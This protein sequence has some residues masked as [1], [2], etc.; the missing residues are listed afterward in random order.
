MTEFVTN[1]EHEADCP[2][3]NDRTALYL[4]RQHAESQEPY[5]TTEDEGEG[6][7]DVAYT[8][9]H[10][11]FVEDLEQM[12]LVCKGCGAETFVTTDESGRLVGF[13]RKNCPRSTFYTG[14]YGELPCKYCGYTSAATAARKGMEK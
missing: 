12:T 7:F 4:Y 5:F 13:T 2:R 3:P 1:V 14:H 6:D 11:D 9:R 8:D 10:W